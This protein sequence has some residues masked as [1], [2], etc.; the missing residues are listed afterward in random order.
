V[1]LEPMVWAATDSDEYNLIRVLKVF[2][3]EV[4][5]KRALF[6]YVSGSTSEGC[7]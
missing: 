5:G 7:L 2:L 3:T 4:S 6:K 1:V